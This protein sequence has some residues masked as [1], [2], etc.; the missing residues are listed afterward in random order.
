MQPG[1]HV[2][3]TDAAWQVQPRHPYRCSL[4][5]AAMSPYSR[6]SLESAA[7]WIILI[8]DAAW[9]VQPCHPIADAA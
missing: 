7:R 3:L 2:T 4:A 5:S 6:C 8:A 9:Q 1:S